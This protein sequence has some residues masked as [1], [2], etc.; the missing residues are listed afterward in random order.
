[1]EVRIDEVVKSKEDVLKVYE[2]LKKNQ[3]GQYL[4]K[5]AQE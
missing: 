3:Y 2:V 4:L 5:V 1:M